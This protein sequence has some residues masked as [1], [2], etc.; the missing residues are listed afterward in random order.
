[1][2][3]LTAF[4]SLRALFAIF[5]GVAVLLA[6]ALGRGD[7]LAAA[8]HHDMQMTSSGDCHS[9]R[10]S[11]RQEGAHHLG[12]MGCCTAMSLGVTPAANQAVEGASDQVAAAPFAPATLHSPFL[13]ELATP[14][15]RSA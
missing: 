13:A 12:D 1:M 7:A 8:P 2:K 10:H 5:I 4:V 14:P 11:D 9:P 3:T 15:P 6:P